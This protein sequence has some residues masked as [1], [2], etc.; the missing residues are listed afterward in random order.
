MIDVSADLGY[1]GA[2]PIALICTASRRFP[3]SST[4]IKDLKKHFNSRT[5]KNKIDPGAGDDRRKR[6]GLPRSDADSFELNHKPPDSGE[7]KFRSRTS[8]ETFEQAMI[9]VSADLG[10]LGA[11]LRA[12][13][14]SPTMAQALW[15]FLLSPAP[16]RMDPDFKSFCLNNGSSQDQNLALTVLSVPDS[17]DRD[18]KQRR[19]SGQW[20]S[21]PPWP[22]LSGHLSSLPTALP[23]ARARRQQLQKQSNFLARQQLKRLCKISPQ[24]WLKP[25][26]KTGR[27]C[28][29]CTEF[30]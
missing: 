26:P 20:I 22:K 8:K 6:L 1:L 4:R 30:A 29:I 25:R 14:L 12:M 13:R 28:L 23:R 15:S 27:D 17:L 19:R 9:D 5:L 21:C 11:T 2:T 16:F 3:A 7:L 24:Q 18:S 10:Y